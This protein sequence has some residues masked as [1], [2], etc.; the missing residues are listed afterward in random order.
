[1]RYYDTGILV[2]LYTIEP[3]S[4]AVQKFVTAQASPIPFHAFHLSET[5]SAF[6]LKAFRRECTVAQANRAMADLEEDLRSGI[7]FE[8]APD[9]QKTW[10]RCLT[11]T[12]AHA[13]LTGC[14]TL[15]TLHIACAMEL[16]AREFVTSDH[17]QAK[18]ATLLGFTVHDPTA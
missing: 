7:L 11:L 13:A 10:D 8:L 1:M 16:G 6:H 3:E 12:R 18:L 9:W 4:A 5:A 14:R 15:D 2:K 17:R